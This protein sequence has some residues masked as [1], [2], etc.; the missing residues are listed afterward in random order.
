[1]SLDAAYG[2]ITDSTVASRKPWATVKSSPV[3]RP[4]RRRSK[5]WSMTPATDM[6]SPEAVDRKAAKAPPASTADSVSPS[7]SG[8]MAPGSRARACQRRRSRQVGQVDAA[9][10]AVDGREEVEGAEQGDD[11]EGRPSG[12]PA[13]GVGV[14]ADQHVGQAHRAEAE[15]EQQAVG[16]V[17]R[18][19][20]SGQAVQRLD[21]LGLLGDGRSRSAVADPRAEQ[22]EG[23]DGD[24][25]E[26]HPVLHGLH[27]GDR[28]HPAGG[29]VGATTTTA[30]ISPPT[31]V[32]RPG[33]A[34]P[35]PDPRPGTGGGGRASRCRR[36][37]PSTA[38]GSRCS[39]A[40]A[41]A[42]SGSV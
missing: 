23:R 38:A 41:S 26:L 8:T 4:S 10:H 6:V 33:H 12:S 25:G 1:M 11:G 7:W 36:R 35:G 29:D 9:E 34:C 13:V 30:T 3:I 2:T 24:G 18:M 27:Q 16:G 21:P 31:H 40:C 28:P 42:K 20:L 39:R 17:D 32:G 22:D 5:S 19:S 37:A 14:E 15:G